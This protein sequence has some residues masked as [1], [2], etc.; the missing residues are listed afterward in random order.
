MRPGPRTL[1][2][3][4][5]AC[6][7]LLIPSVA[8]AHLA[9]RRSHPDSGAR[10]DRAPTAIT[11]WFTQRPQLGFSRLTL[12][13]PGGEI[14]LGT[15]AADTGNAIRAAIASPLAPGS[16]TV[17]WQTASADG[18]PIRGTFRFAIGAA[19]DT[20][21]AAAPPEVPAHLHEASPAAHGD[22][23]LYRGVRWIE[24]VALM[25]V[26]GVV[27]FHHLVLP[28]LASRGV[29]TADAFNRAR[30]LG[31]SVLALY[32]PAALIRLYAESAVVHGPERALEWTGLRS[33]LAD[34]MWGGG[35]MLGVAGAAVV[36]VGWR[37]ARSGLPG[38]TTLAAVG[39][40]GLALSPALTGH[41]ASGTPLLA[42][43]SFDAVHVLTAGLW[44]GGLLILLIAGVP[45]MLK[46]E[47][48]R[49]D[50]AVAAMVNSFHPVAL[51]AAP[52]VLL[53][54]VGSAWMRL[55]TPTRILE[56]D[57]GRVLLIKVMLVLCVAVLGVHNSARARRRLGTADATRLFR[58]TA[59]A[60]VVIA[61]VVLAVTTILIVTPLPPIPLFR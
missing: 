17:S 35:W 54:G 13:G 56:S 18:H 37:L 12:V 58:L 57:Y 41:A 44:V 15:L 55:G 28:A 24:F 32:L 7:G 9:L 3:I 42:S 19:T 38:S 52:L 4:V 6:L 46:L 51:L 33:M 23:P 22:N 36:L 5:I 39:G 14:A 61:A 34:T 48:G 59:W 2:V 30:R 43:V 11:L 47:N 26:L 40:L 49:A 8:S 1:R 31:Q 16:Y 60:E 27:G 10:L 21:A 45:A 20:T 53:T 25:T 29:A 50:A